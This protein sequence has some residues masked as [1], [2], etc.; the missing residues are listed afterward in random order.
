MPRKSATLA[1]VCLASAVAALCSSTAIALPVILPLTSE[2]R[3]MTGK[4][5]GS[6]SLETTK[7]EKIVCSAVTGE[8][9]QETASS[10]S[11]H[12]HF[13]GCESAGLKCNTTGDEAGVI[14]ILGELHLVYDSLSPLSVAVL[15]SP[16]EVVLK[17][18]ALVTLKM[19]GNEL[20][21]G[22]E[23]TVHAFTHWDHCVQSKGKSTDE[24]YWNDAGA[25]QTAS[26]LL[27]KNG[28]AFVECAEL[29]LSSATSSEELWAEI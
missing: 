14:L 24:H 3:A 6:V 29:A 19:K 9:V 18:T 1:A 16:G 10:G 8:G 25:E 20:C 7:A 23:P 11:F 17:C 12:N 28:A 4:S 21:H 15:L 22:L 13:T 5:E 27:S 2:P 26:L